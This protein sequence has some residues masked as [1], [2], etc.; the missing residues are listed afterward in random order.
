MV[1]PGSIIGGFIIAVSIAIQVITLVEIAQYW[2]LLFIWSAG[3]IA[4][5][6]YVLGGIDYGPNKMEY[7][8]IS[9]IG[10][11]AIV[12][13]TAYFWVFQWDA[14]ETTLTDLVNTQENWVI[15]AILFSTTAA[16]LMTIAPIFISY[17]SNKQLKGV[18]PGSLIG[19]FL[20]SL[21]LALQVIVVIHFEKFYWLLVFWFVGL[22]G[23]IALA[24]GA[25]AKGYNSTESYVIAGIS[26]GIL[27]IL[28]I[29]WTLSP[30]MRELMAEASNNASTP[31]SHGHIGHVWPTIMAF[32]SGVVAFFGVSFSAAS[33]TR[34]Y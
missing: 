24:A 26:I 5:V 9:G 1:K 23:A 10:W 12:S 14:I 2:W 34:R 13:L 28:V 31:P 19:G 18:K 15:G 25:R 22:I 20:I 33:D 6:T 30:H 7:F 29:W 17:G 8:T 4:G 16:I 11:G 32:I 27:L 21:S 3:L